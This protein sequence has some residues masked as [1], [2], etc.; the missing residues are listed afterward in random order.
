MVIKWNLLE[1]YQGLRELAEGSDEVWKVARNQEIAGGLGNGAL[2]RSWEETAST[3]RLPLAWSTSSPS[4]QLR[5]THSR[6][7]VLAGTSGCPHLDSVPT[8]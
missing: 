1:G 2:V 3:P 7:Q 8:R 6:C 5:I 4:S